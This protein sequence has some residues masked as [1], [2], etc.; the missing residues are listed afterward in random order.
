MERLTQWRSRILIL[1]FTTLLCFYAFKLFD[2]QIVETG[3]IVDNTTTFT[4]WT[5]VKA[6]RGEILDRNGKVLVGN[7]ASYNLVINHFVLT[8]AK[9]PNQEIYNLVTLCN[10]HGIEY[11]DHLPITK[12]KPFTYTLEEYS[13]LW[14]SYFQI[15]LSNRGGLD[16]DISA[17]LLIDMLRESYGIPEDWTDEEARMVLGIRYELTLRSLT[18]LSTFEFVQDAG[19]ADL[20]AV[21]ELNTPGLTVEASTVREYYTEYAA[22]ILGYV[23]N[24]SDKQWEHYK[25]KGYSMDA[26]VGQTGFELAF[27]DALH[28]TDGIRV[29]EVT[30]DGTVVR[31]YF[32]QYPVAG[33]NV[34]VTI[35]IDLQETAE[36][37]LASQMEFLRNQEMPTD[38]AEDPPDGLDAQGA[39]VVAIDVAT[40]QVLVC[41]SYPTYHPATL[42]LDFDELLE[43]EFDP[44]FN[45]ALKAIY[46]P[47]S[48]YKMSSVVAAIDYGYIKSTDTIQD[49]GVFNKYAGFSPKCLRYANKSGTHGHITASE[50]LCVSCNY[51]F[52]ELADNMPISVFD[53]TAKAMGLGEP[54]GVELP[55]EI[56]YRSNEETKKLLYEGDLA[57]WRQGDKIL[58][59]IGQA[60]NKFT[61]MQLCVYA[62]TLANQ[63]V[64]MKATFLNQ[65]VSADY[66]TRLQVNEP[67]VANV[68]KISDDAFKAY[69]EGMQMVTSYLTYYMVGTAY[70]T[71]HDYPIKV[72]GKTG[73]AQHGITTADDH[74]AF[75]CYAPADSTPKIAIAVYGE[76][77][78]HGS[79]MAIVARDMLDV[80]FSTS[81][82]ST[83]P[84]YENQ[85][86]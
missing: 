50:A 76:R 62:S 25:D 45:R 14:Q 80:Y 52:Y 3:G 57:E 18:T 31:S 54:T 26:E 43:V 39:A 36:K 1:L 48:T 24:M 37:A 4:T 28:A 75:I 81:D 77:V 61:P 56:G 59:T 9:S 53:N 2:L 41:A 68:L 40:G 30:A 55:E 64:R 85:V 51:F 15:F 23:G 17:P 78:G 42:R 10:E 79:S 7:R 11:V 63:G 47:G 19:D 44:L 49:L 29:D 60:E 35:D 66:R 82:M 67:E 32:K 34:E 33:N 69:N 86:S 70:E 65:I 72:A 58:T 84:V 5:R 27:E 8:S 73:T 21:L 74:G 38:P 20:S 16:S 46:P 12:T 71:F 13:P 83:V 6:A 22:H